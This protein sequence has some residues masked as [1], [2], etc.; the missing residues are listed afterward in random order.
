MVLFGDLYERGISLQINLNDVKWIEKSEMFD[1]LFNQNLVCHPMEQGM[2]AEVMKL[3]SD[4]DSFVMK[5]WNKSSKP[6]IQ[7]QYRLLNVLLERGLSVSKPL[8]CGIDANN[9]QVL[10]TSFDGIVVHRLDAN[11]SSH[12]A[13]LLLGI[14]Q[15]DATEL[16][17]IDLPKYDFINYFFFMA[18]Q[19]DDLFHIVTSLVQLTTINHDHIIHGD[20]HLRN[21]VEDNDR[22]TIIDWT[23]IQLGDYRY[24]F[25]W[26]YILKKI[27]TT[28]GIAEAFRST[29]LLQKPIKGEEL[30]IF[31]A[32]ACLRWILLNRVGGTPEEPTTKD[33]VKKIINSNPF[34]SKLELHSI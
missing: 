1:Q 2:E 6:N 18:G 21:I 22:Y 11:I 9:N 28:D 34:L 20:F 8:G 29:Y 10:L 4:T 25:A 7:L 17:N 19:S 3:T 27:Y 5:V 16:E 12:I 26:S 31:V 32:L 15:I 13:N 23:N 24:D 30:E 33:R 14:H